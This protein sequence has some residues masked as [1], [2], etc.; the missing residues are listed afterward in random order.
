MGL[1]RKQPQQWLSHALVRAPPPPSVWANLWLASNQQNEARER[2]TSGSTLCKTVTTIFANSLIDPLSMS[3]FD[4]VC[5]HLKRPMGQGTE[6]A[7][8]TSLQGRLIF[9]SHRN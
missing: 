9:I 8:A 4:E 1:H 7:S 5:D 2:L 3:G 6:G